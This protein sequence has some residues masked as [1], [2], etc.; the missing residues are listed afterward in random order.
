MGTLEQ[1]IDWMRRIF[2]GQESYGEGTAAEQ[3]NQY[4]LAEMYLE[5]VEAAR[6]N[7]AGVERPSF[8]LLVSLSGF[9]PE[10]TLLAFE[11][12]EPGR[13]LV[14]SSAS[15]R[16]KVNV[17]HEKLKGRLE[18]S[19]FQHAIAIRSIPSKSTS[20]SRERCDCDLLSRLCGRSSTSR[21]ARR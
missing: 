11:L 19:E 10:T 18:F 15:T 14:I 13:L 17:I 5:V 2:R 9:S 21:A 3:A 6:K 20:S 8:D 16:S 4:R 1:K 7:S 12:L